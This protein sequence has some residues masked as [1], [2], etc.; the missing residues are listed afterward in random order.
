M[1]GRANH[2]V[3]CAISKMASASFRT[4]RKPQ[5]PEHGARGTCGE[6]RNEDQ[7]PHVSPKQGFQAGPPHCVWGVILTRS[8]K[9]ESP[10]TMKFKA[11]GMG[12]HHQ[13]YLKLPRRVHCAATGEN[14]WSGAGLC[15]KCCSNA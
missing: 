6:G 13:Y 10:W 2:P 9:P 4:E 3:V 1:A 12:P 15:S 5:Q 14:P 7:Q 11:L 8:C